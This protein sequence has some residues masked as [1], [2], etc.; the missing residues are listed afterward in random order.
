MS[1]G[2]GGSIITIPMLVY[3][4]NFAAKEVVSIS[5]FVSIIANGTMLL[6]VISERHPMFD[7][8]LIDYNLLVSMNISIFIGLTFGVFLN[9]ILPQIIF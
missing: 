8:P 5:V 6:Q 7:R 1:A 9:Q 4:L 3:C 2:I